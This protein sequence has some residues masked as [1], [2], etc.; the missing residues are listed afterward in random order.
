MSEHQ[1]DCVL[2]AATVSDGQQ[3]AA[4]AAVPHT[5]AYPT[6]SLT[7]SASPPIF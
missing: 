3:T 2:R 5:P 4:A 6:P 1:A 7:P